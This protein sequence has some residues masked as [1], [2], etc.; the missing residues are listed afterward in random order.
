MII[1][2][3]NYQKNEILN[4]YLQ[5]IISRFI[6]F[7]LA[8]Q[9]PYLPPTPNS[10]P[11]NQNHQSNGNVFQFGP[12]ALSVMRQKQG[13]YPQLSPDPSPVPQGLSLF[14][15][16]SVPYSYWHLLALI[17]LF[18]SEPSEVDVDWSKR[19]TNQT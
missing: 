3:Y 4:V 9:S 11:I 8:G 13:G 14:Y 10:V 19:V 17:Q 16:S 1:R 12:S 5:R 18:V 7:F 2:K 6:F 15:V